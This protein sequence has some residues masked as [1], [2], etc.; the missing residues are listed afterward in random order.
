MKKLAITLSDEDFSRLEKI[1]NQK[2]SRR[3]KS[4]EISW[5]ILQ[6]WD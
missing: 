3:S 4:N 5:L 2:Y 1:R 6:E